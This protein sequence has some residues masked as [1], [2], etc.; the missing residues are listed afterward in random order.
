MTAATASKGNGQE[1]ASE[2]V[3]VHSQ[4][5]MSALL[6]AIHDCWFEADRIIWDP[7]SGSVTIPFERKFYHLGSVR[8]WWQLARRTEETRQWEL[9]VRNVSSCDVSD[10]EKVGRY[11]FNTIDY[12]ASTGHLEFKTGVPIGIVLQVSA[13]CIEAR[14]RL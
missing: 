11:D 7:Q 14:P 6:D 2:S 13:L 10:T 12:D 4:A 9:V 5:G 1:V 3:V 8:K